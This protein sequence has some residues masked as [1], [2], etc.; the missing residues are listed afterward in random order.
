[1]K[2]PAKVIGTVFVVAVLTLL[3]AIYGISCMNAGYALSFDQFSEGLL[4]HTSNCGGNSAAGTYCREIALIVEVK[5]ADSNDIFEFN[6]ISSDCRN[7]LAHIS[8]SW[9]QEAKYLLRKGPVR[10]GQGTHEIV[11]VCNTAYGNVPQPTLWNLHHRTF[12]HAVGYSDG[13][14]GWLTPAEFANLNKSN[15][16]ALEFTPQ[17]AQNG[18]NVFQ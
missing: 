6:S 16:F 17:T 3:A 7:D 9:T 8:T 5:G 2:P 12:V 11:V 15:F 10:T 1:M 14:L 13:T 18:T 4:G